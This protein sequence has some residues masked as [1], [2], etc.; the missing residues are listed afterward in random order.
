MPFFFSSRAKRWNSSHFNWLKI[1]PTRMSS[2]FDSDRHDFYLAIALGNEWRLSSFFLSPNIFF[3]FT[4]SSGKGYFQNPFHLPKTVFESPSA[5]L[6]W[7][8]KTFFPFCHLAADKKSLSSQ[9]SLVVVHADSAP[10]FFVVFVFF[11]C[12][13]GEGFPQ[14]KSQHLSAKQT[15]YNSIL[16]AIA[17]AKALQYGAWPPFFFFFFSSLN[18]TLHYITFNLILH[19][20]YL[21]L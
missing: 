11:F 3:F 9:R 12:A 5:F 8:F 7:R 16:H 2:R 13:P 14:K 18:L 15:R 4:A 1:C 20:I 21:E 17:P 6:A 19:Y 10:S